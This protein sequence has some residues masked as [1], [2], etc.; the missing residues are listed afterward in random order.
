M[1]GSGQWAE[2]CRRALTAFVRSQ[3]P[4][5]AAEEG[6][7]GAC[8][9]STASSM[10][11]T[12]TMTPRSPKSCATTWPAG[13]RRPSRRRGCSS[14]STR[15]APSL[16]SVEGGPNDLVLDQLHP[17]RRDWRRRPV[18]PR[19]RARLGRRG[20]SSRRRRWHAAVRTAAGPAPAR[21]CASA[22]A[23]GWKAVSARQVRRR[24]FCLCG[25]RQ[26]EASPPPPQ[27]AQHTHTQ[28]CINVHTY[29]QA[30]MHS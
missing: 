4:T 24:R 19:C 20:W 9:C 30:G 22:S 6:R 13:S 27:A 2:P 14:S 25:P 12:P 3:K 10:P 18:G 26:K 17:R 16:V 7:G 23:P 5:H 8:C 21:P 1:G 29:V 11:T 28:A 15:S